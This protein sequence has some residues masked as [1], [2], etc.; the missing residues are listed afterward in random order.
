MQ[1]KQRSDEL[2]KQAKNEVMSY[3]TQAKNEVM[4]YA[5]QAK[6]EVM[7]WKEF[8]K[9]FGEDTTTNIQLMQMAKILKI[10]NFYYVM[11][12][13]INMLPK[14]MSCMNV[15]TNIHTSKENGV[16][17]SCF[18]MSRMTESASRNRVS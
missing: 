11:R 14:N 6:N 1:R 10:P 9:R 12:D 17:H 13:E 4:S 2:C 16:H 18:Y 5:T 8:R 7:S 3:A 15:A